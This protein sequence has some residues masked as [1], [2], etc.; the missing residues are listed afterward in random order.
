MSQPECY[1]CLVI[2]ARSPCGNSV[3][4]KA[5]CQSLLLV[6]SFRHSRVIVGEKTMSIFILVSMAP[7]NGPTVQG[8]RLTAIYKMEGSCYLIFEPFYA[9]H[10]LVNTDTETSP[11][12]PPIWKNLFAHHLFSCVFP[13]IC[14]S[15]SSQAPDH[16]A[17][18]SDT[19][20]ESVCNHTAGCFPST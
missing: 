5:P 19:V 3:V 15:C 1:Y 10:L 12:S 18:A 9:C 7:V 13:I 20:S 14:Q 11:H 6:L 2:T 8:K 16:P 17:K 4:L